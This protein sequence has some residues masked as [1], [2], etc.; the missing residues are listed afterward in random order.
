MKYVTVSV[1]GFITL[2]TFLIEAIRL[3]SSALEVVLAGLSSF[4][5]KHYG[6]LGVQ[7]GVKTRYL[8]IESN[9]LLETPS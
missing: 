2:K 7:K 8:G 5:L 6:L 9:F 3:L 1:S 4:V